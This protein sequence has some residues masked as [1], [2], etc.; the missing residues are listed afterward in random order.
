MDNDPDELTSSLV[1]RRSMHD[2]CETEANLLTK[3]LHEGTRQPPRT[4]ASEKS[5]EEYKMQHSQQS[6]D[7]FPSG[8]ALSFQMLNRAAYPKMKQ[9]ANFFASST[10]F[11]QLSHT[12]EQKEKLS[13]PV[14]SSV[15][16][17]CPV[18][19][20]PHFASFTHQS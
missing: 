19:Q 12:E 17:S 13:S 11:I 18:S 16:L 3:E 14:A 6:V 1:S 10:N 9:A 15:P 5:D 4:G 20:F 8:N 7:V 2:R